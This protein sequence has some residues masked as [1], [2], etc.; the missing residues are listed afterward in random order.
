MKTIV[1]VTA[2]LVF[3]VPAAAQ[4]DS[5]GKRPAVLK[6][7][8]A[9]PVSLRGGKFLAGERVTVAAHSAGVKRS[10]VVTAGAAGAFVARFANLPFDRCQGF[11]A[12]A[13][14]A[15]GSEARLKLPELMCPPRL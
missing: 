7:A 6:L 5:A 12:V 14:G 11:L 3:A 9:H 8:G 13:R 4:L 10:R 2:L 15:R 1:A